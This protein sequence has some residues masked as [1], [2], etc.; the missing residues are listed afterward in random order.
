MR[1]EHKYYVYDVIIDLGI[2]MTVTTYA[3]FLMSIGLT[4]GEVSLINAAFWAVIALAEIPTGMLADGKSRVWSLKMGCIFFTCGGL[5]YL[6][7]NGFWGALFSECVSGIGMAFFSGAEQA[8]VTDALHKEGRDHERR[9]I[10]ATASALRGCVLVAGGVIGSLIALSHARLIWLPMVVTSPIAWIFVHTHMSGQGE[11]HQKMTEVEALRASVSLLKSSRALMWVIGMMFVFGA[12]LSFNHFWSPYFK[13]L[14]G[15]MGL[16]TVWAA[17]YTGFALSALLVRRLVI[18]QGHEAVWIVGAAV[19][20]GIGLLLAGLVSGLMLPL[21]MAL[22]HECGR[23][24]FHPLV[25][26]FIQHRVESGY[27][28]TF[29]SLQSLL[30]K[31]SFVLVPALVWLTI[32]DQPNTQATISVVWIACGCALVTGSLVL[33]LFR[34]K[35]GA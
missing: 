15:T 29:S 17:V 14:V 23:G 3:P 18:P 13:P 21:S 16:S 28:A 34:P 26:S 6:F 1:T 5:S 9:R 35:A 2:A 12:V 24:M 4:L 30:S 25:D 27:R 20:A 31:L 10:F 32:R 19:M 11:S 33:F 8:W 7:V 22:L